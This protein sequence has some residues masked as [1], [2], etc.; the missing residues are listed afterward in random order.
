MFITIITQTIAAVAHAIM[1]YKT[2]RRTIKE[3]SFLTDRELNDIGISRCDIP[4][5]AK[6]EV[7]DKVVTRKKIN[8]FAN[9]A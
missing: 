2:E 8:W 6:Y 4:E 3:L 1:V 7:T 5:I 9:H